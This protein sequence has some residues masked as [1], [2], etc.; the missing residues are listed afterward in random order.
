MKNPQDPFDMPFEA[1]IMQQIATK[2]KENLHLQGVYRGVYNAAGTT[3][4]A[5]MDGFL[6]LIAAA[7]TATDIAPVV[8]GAVTADNVID[9]AELV[10]DSLGE[11]YKNVP[12]QMIVSPTIFDW[13]GRKYRSLYNG[14]PLY[15]GIKKTG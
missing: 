7:I 14:S 15:T 13:Y 11:G 3:P 6:T 1:F 9:K 12:T 5:T 2:V 4:I 8:T 10:Y